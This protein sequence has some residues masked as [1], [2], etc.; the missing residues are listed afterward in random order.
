MT[1]QQIYE[2]AYYMRRLEED[3]TVK[4]IFEPFDS[5][6]GLVYKGHNDKYLMLINSEISYKK[7]IETI[8]HESK[9]IYSHC[10]YAICS[11]GD[12]EIFEKEA[13]LFSKHTIKISNEVISTCR[14][15]W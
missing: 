4:I 10:E 1:E 5:I 14:N 15:A 3:N 11:P 2:V 13:E 8:W 6:Y 12:V 7:Q 9:H